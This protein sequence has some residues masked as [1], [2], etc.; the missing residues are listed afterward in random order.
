M[1]HFKVEKN[2]SLYYEIDGEGERKVIMIMG[3]AGTLRFFDKTVAGLT[4]EDNNLSILRLDNRG[5]GNSVCEMTRQ[6]TT[7]LAKD[8][9][10]LLNHI[11]WTEKVHVMGASMG[12]MIAQELALF[13]YAKNRLASLYLSVSSRKR[14]PIPIPFGPNVWKSIFKVARV[15]SI[16]KEKMAEMMLA[17]AYTDDYLNETDRETGKKNREIITNEF[18]EKFETDMSWNLDVLAAQS[19]ACSTHYFDDWKCKKLRDSGIPIT[20]QIAT[21][22]KVMPTAGQFD[23]AERLNAT[24]VIFEGGHLCSR[25]DPE[26]FHKSI[27][28]TINQA[29]PTL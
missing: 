13:L 8:C 27:L 22:D 4:E 26:R 18:L 10:Y 2:T 17:T 25:T 24:K 20:C 16:S 29:Q 5:A 3:F 6:T 28:A 15:D 9:L 7:M 12:G 1:P 19:C 11:G 23:L 14:Y 21:L